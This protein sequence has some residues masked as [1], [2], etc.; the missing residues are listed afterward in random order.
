M[1]FSHIGMTDSQFSSSFYFFFLENWSEVSTN[2]N[3]F[4][5]SMLHVFRKYQLLVKIL[6]TK[7]TRQVVYKVAFAMKYPHPTPPPMNTTYIP[8][9]GANT[10]CQKTGSLG[11][12]HTLRL[13]GP[14]FGNWA[15]FCIHYGVANGAK[16]GT[17]KWQCLIKLA[18]W[19]SGLLLN[20]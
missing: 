7:L 2:Y 14:I 15:E 13:T 19:V 20:T 17:R 18:Q 6:R 16:I 4:K 3:T 9:Y 5:Y 12:T 1:F 8:K 11:P 10:I